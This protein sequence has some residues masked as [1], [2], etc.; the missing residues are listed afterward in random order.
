MVPRDGT[1][2]AKDSGQR[3]QISF[4]TGLSGNLRGAMSSDVPR[5]ESWYILRTDWRFRSSNVEFG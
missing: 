4:G 1:P 2:M 3:C 5:E